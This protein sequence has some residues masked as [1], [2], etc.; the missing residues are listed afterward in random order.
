MSSSPSPAPAGAPPIDGGVV[1][2]GTDGPAPR[3]WWL[4]L[5]SGLL[6][7]L[8][9]VLALAVPGATVLFLG[10]LFGVSLM[11]TGVATIATGLTG[12]GSAG[13]QTLSV[14]LGFV[15]TLAGL[16]CF[17]RPG[18]GIAAVLLTV[19]FWFMLTGI[20]DLVA[21]FHEQRHRFWRILLGVIGIAAGVVLVV[22]PVIGLQTVALLAGLGF[23]LRGSAEI[24][25]ALQLRRVSRG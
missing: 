9:G 4:V 15:A 1:V 16:I 5:I 14:L 24:G 18:A 22:D 8:V 17:V 6:S 12:E 10:L 20:G 7:V 11:I 21:G 19:A 13:R 2:T 23:L 25:L 3:L